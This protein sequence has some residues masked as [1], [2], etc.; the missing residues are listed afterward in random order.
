MDLNSFSHGYG[1]L[2][3]HIVLVPKYR[4][5]I[6]SDEEVKKGCERIFKKIAREYGYKIHELQIM[7]DHLHFFVGSKPEHSM[8][9]TMQLFKGI[10]ARRLFQQYPQI[11][12]KL[13]GSHLWSRGK[14]FRSVGNVTADT[15]QHYIAQ[16]QGKKPRK[17]GQ[18]NLGD[19][20]S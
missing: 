12:K 5:D 10:S 1:Q 3:Y 18:T 17:K 9:Q 2:S 19:F 8:A 15:I 4:R 16:S 20:A 11:K 14:F 13:W 7:R 6:F